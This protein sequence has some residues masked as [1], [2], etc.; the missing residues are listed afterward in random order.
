MSLR[1]R[2]AVSLA[3]IAAF[4]CA[5]AATGAYLATQHQLQK[6]IDTS[7][8]ERAQSVNGTNP[9]D[10]NGDHPHYGDDG[11]PPAGLVQPAAAAQIVK[12]DGTVT[13]CV[14]GGVK[15]PVTSADIAKAGT[16]G[17]K[18]KLST[19]TVHGTRYRVLAI[20]WRNGGLLQ[21]A[22][23]LDETQS[24]LSSLQLQ[25]VF[26]SLAGIAA[27]ALLGWLFARRLVRPIVRLRNVAE[28]IARTQ[29]LDA[30]VP[31]TGGGEIGSLAVSFS[32]MVDALSKS[33]RQQQQLITD[34]S[35]EFRTPLTSLRT[36]AELLDRSERLS[37]QQRRS[38]VEGIQL[39]VEELSNLFSELVELA[40][41]QSNDEPVQAVGLRDLAD[42]AANRARR[43]TGREVTV[44]G[45]GD[46][47]NVRPHL[48]DRAITNL[49]DNALK[50]SDGPVELV[51]T[52]RRFEVRD[53]G[54]GFNAEDI[55]HVFDRFYRSNE[56]RTEPGSGLGLA[57][58]QQIV[59]RHGGTVWATDRDE[60]GA[61]VGFEL[62]DGH[63][64]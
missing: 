49:V 25:L 2:I 19:V 28:R 23:S 1:W 13:V 15:L 38:V 9:V 33:R 26:L 24:V 56:A 55:P 10:P 57:I 52:G 12:P 32:T 48:I 50:Y 6:S 44:T 62:T 36:N 64:G 20:P 40:T 43:R 4:I 34:A 17:G 8:L 5:L 63:A 47:V 3:V 39:E 35:H 46:T 54:P 22:R 11:C 59:E 53:V 61:A 60:G 18:P 29:E 45:T 30:P 27:A 16:P 7:L 14:A 41:D 58:V 31:Q 37:D 42:D 51:L 21:T